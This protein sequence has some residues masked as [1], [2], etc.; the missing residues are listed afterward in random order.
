MPWHGLSGQET[1]QWERRVEH[2]M[3]ESPCRNSLPRRLELPCLRK[4]DVSAAGEFQEP[5]RYSLPCLAYPSSS[6]CR[7]EM[8]VGGAE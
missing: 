6:S 3:P 2:L 1:H 5:S 8:R 7:Q 4:A